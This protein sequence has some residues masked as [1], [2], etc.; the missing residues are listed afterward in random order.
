M[1]TS[2]CDSRLQSRREPSEF[3][4]QV[5]QARTRIPSVET[6]LGAA[7]L[8]RFPTPLP[9]FPFP[10]LG[11]ARLCSRRGVG[12]LL[13]RRFHF[14]YLRYRPGRDCSF[15]S[16]SLR[17]TVLNRIST[18]W[19][20]SGIRSL[21][22]PANLLVWVSSFTPPEQALRRVSLPPEGGMFTKTA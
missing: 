17:G 15:L 16:R 19:R 5:R 22:F 2:G 14:P 18:S 20:S 3:Q 4:L 11:S 10:C 12:Y 7:V 13:S 21:C 8:V 9:P 1:L 6:L